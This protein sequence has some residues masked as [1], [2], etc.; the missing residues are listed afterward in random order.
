MLRRDALG[1]PELEL[2]GEERDEDTGAP[3]GNLPCEE[4]LVPLADLEAVA[5]A[6]GLVNVLAVGVVRG[7]ALHVDAPYCPGLNP[8]GAALLPHTLPPL[9]C[10]QDRRHT[11]DI[12]IKNCCF[13]KKSVLL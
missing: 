3:V 11:E 5:L 1:R 13:R 4:V 6:L 2:V 9:A 7:P 12:F 10:E 8:P